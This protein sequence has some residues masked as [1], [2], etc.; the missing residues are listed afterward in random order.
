MNHEREIFLEA[1]DQ[2]TEK[3]RADFVE[4]ATAGD[5]KL[6]K[7]VGALLACN[8]ADTIRIEEGAF[9]ILRKSMEAEGKLAIGEEWRL[10]PKCRLVGQ[11]VRAGLPLVMVTLVRHVRSHQFNKSKAVSGF[12]A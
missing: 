5:A 1:L 2:P 3:A 11:Q 9:E 10:I 4:Q 7:T 12:Y 8:Q 6:R